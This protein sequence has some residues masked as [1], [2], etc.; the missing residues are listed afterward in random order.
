MDQAARHDVWASGDPYERY[1]GRWS[2]KVAPEFL[3]W[4]GMAPGL[5]WLDV[6]CGTGALSQTILDQAT[7]KSV[8]GV[9]ASAGFL[10]Y[11]KANI[12]D[13]RASFAVGDAQSLPVDDAS[14]DIAVS[15][16]VM[17]FVP[18]PLRMAADMAR[19][20]RPGGTVAVYV[21]D[22]SGQMGM[23]RV[24]WSSATELDAHAADEGPRFALC[25]PPALTAV[26]SEAKLERVEVRP[27]DVP[28]VFR[29]FED[30]WSPF[31]G[32]QGPGP[33]YVLS[34]NPER[35]NALRDRIRSKLPEEADGSIRLTARAWAVRGRKG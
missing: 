5:D 24:F 1:V 27:I 26:F 6:G 12:R 35:R 4:L 29:S 25:H 16:L 17:N 8:K 3:A 14:V 28:T 31:L 18:E 7:P 21:W 9:D 33:A 32:G 34:L 11:A 22:Y 13:P 15:G 2:R 10:E 19:A 30:Y 20:A 23:M